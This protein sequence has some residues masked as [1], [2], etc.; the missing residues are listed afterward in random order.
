MHDCGTPIKYWRGLGN[1]VLNWMNVK[2]QNIKHRRGGYVTVA[3]LAI[4]LTGY[5]SL[6]YWPHS[7]CEEYQ[8]GVCLMNR[9]T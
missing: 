3:M 1:M 6:R 7:S 9:E 2:G 4:V 5:A 8:R